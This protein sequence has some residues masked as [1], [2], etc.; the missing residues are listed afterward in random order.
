[1]TA[2][3]S[4]RGLTWMGAGAVGVVFAFFAVLYLKGDRDPAAQVASKAKRV[5]AVHRL[6]IYL[7][8]A[9]EAQN[10]ALMSSLEQDSQLFANQA[11]VATA[12]LDREKIELQ[13]LLTERGDTQHLELMDRVAGSLSE[14]QQIDKQLLD[15][16]VQSSNRKAFSLAFGPAMKILV[17]I[18][19]PLSRII[20]NHASSPTSDNMRVLQLTA[21]VRIG[22]LR[23]QVLLFPHIAEASDKKMDEL[24]TQLSKE[25]DH[26][27]ESLTAIR[28]LIPE[29][30]RSLLELATTRYA[31]FEKLKLQIIKLS[32]ANTDVRAVAIALKEKRMAMLACEDAL[33]TLERAIQAEP[34]SSLIPAG[35]SK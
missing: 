9:S 28:K 18:D 7:A 21:D 33:A 24:E 15:L 34:I 26:V 19:A 30:E 11:R 14:F 32:R 16:A 20:E 10:N 27:N 17:E 1:M 13:K 2:K 5:E 31:E 6:R 35:R 23:M 29:S 4:S 25:G 12:S 22:V 8:A 3:S